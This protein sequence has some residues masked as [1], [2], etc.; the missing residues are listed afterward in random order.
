MVGTV[1]RSL[2]DWMWPFVRC[3]TGATWDHVLVLVAGALLS[4]G[5]R[6]VSAALRV[7]DLDQSGLRPSRWC[8]LGDGHQHRKSGRGQRGKGRF[9]T[10]GH[11]GHRFQR[12]VTV[13]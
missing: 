6:T 4:P 13:L 7:L 11:T 10:G 1:P 3:F 5:R 9:I 12:Q 8:K 2:V